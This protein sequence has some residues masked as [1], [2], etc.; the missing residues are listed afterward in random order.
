VGRSNT[1]Y[2]YRLGDE[3]IESS[4]AKNDFGVLVDKVNMTW[5]RALTAQ[6]GNCILGCIK[7]STASR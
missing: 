3:G 5:Q 7:S 2:Q 4:P 6:K 1:W